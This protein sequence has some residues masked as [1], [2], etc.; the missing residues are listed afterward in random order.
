MMDGSW[1]DAAENALAG[2]G[3]CRGQLE[4]LSRK[5]TAPNAISREQHRRHAIRI[6]LDAEERRLHELLGRPVHDDTIELVRDATR[7]VDAISEQIA[8]ELSA[9]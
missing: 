8:T 6:H 4:E 2:I 5:C 1:V 9:L 7:R 3:V